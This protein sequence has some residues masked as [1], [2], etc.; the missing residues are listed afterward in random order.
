MDPYDQYEV[1]VPM[2][3]AGNCL[4]MVRLGMHK[5]A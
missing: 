1:S 2:D 4:Q 3:Q 5:F